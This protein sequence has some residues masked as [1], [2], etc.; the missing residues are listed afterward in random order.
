VKLLRSLSLLPILLVPAFCQT[1][2]I[3]LVSGKP[4]RAEAKVSGVVLH[5]DEATLNHETGELIMRGHVHVTLP[6]E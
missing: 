5:A 3:D 6:A 2:R 4:G 1:D